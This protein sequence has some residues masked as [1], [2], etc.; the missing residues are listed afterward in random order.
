MKAHTS[1][2]APR[3][4]G[5]NR[6]TLRGLARELTPPVLTRALRKLTGSESE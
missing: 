2:F 3:L 1:I 6:L 4:H 5:T